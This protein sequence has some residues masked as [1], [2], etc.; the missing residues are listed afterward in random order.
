M[1]T[2]V[3][4]FRGPLGVAALLLAAPPARAELRETASVSGAACQDN[5]MWGTVSQAVGQLV[6]S[7]QGVGN[8]GTAP[9][10]VI[11]PVP[12]NMAG[13]YVQLGASGSTCATDT[14]YRPWVDVYDGSVADHVNCTMVERSPNGTQTDWWSTYSSDTGTGFQRLYFQAEG[15]SLAVGRSLEVWCRLP[16][17][18][19]N[20]SFIFAIGVPSC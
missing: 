20:N 5:T 7:T 9:A 13:N 17:V 18:Y 14:S 4:R 15:H 12:V 2:L 8:Q 11:C 1:R 6:Y 16:A 3:H 19:P 10:Y